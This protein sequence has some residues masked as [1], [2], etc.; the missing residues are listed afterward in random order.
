MVRFRKVTVLPDWS[1]LTPAFFIT[2]FPKSSC[3]G[4]DPPNEKRERPVFPRG[5]GT[6]THRPRKSV[7]SIL[8]FVCLLSILKPIKIHYLAKETSERDMAAEKGPVR[9]KRKFEFSACKKNE[10]F[11]ITNFVFS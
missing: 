2:Y 10:N 6:A 11:V 4:T 1:A 9:T 8:F 7:L 5:M 3:S